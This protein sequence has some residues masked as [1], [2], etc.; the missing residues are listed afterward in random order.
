[1]RADV[2]V[3]DPQRPPVEV[4]LGVGVGQRPTHLRHDVEPEARRQRRA[5]AVRPP[6][7]TPQ[8][9][10]VDQLHHQEEPAAG[11]ADVEDLDDVVV[12]EAHRDVGLVDQHVAELLVGVE[13]GEDPF[14]DH[15]FLEPLR[16][17]LL[18]Q[19]DLGHAAFRDLPDDGVA[20]VPHGQPKNPTTP[21]ARRDPCRS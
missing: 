10:A 5:G 6:H 13:G 3:D 14:E 19:E 4:G 12:V 16:A 8:V 11:L 20:S 21:G 1:V 15:H 2:A 18:G 7:Q 9:P 17:V